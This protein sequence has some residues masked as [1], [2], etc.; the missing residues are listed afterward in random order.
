M[1]DRTSLVNQ[2]VL[3]RLGRIRES[4]PPPTDGRGNQL[5]KLLGALLK[6]IDRERRRQVRDALTAGPHGQVIHVLALSRL[7]AWLDLLHKQLL[8]YVADIGRRDIPLGIV[9]L[10]EGLVSDLLRGKADPIIHLNESYMYSTLAVQRSVKRV[11]D[12]WPLQVPI[13]RG[14]EPV[15]FNLPG[16]DHSNALLAPILAHE[17]GHVAVWQRQ[18]MAR[19]FEA[20]DRGGIEAAFQKYAAAINPANAADLK[21]VMEPVMKQFNFWL[22]ELLCDALAIELTGP[23]FLFACA[24]FLPAPHQGALGGHPFP[25]DRVEL[26][27]DHLDS[28]GWTDVLDELAPKTTVF[29]RG[30]GQP[31]SNDATE[32]FLREAVRIASPAIR[33]VAAAAV[34][35]HRLNPEAFR[36]ARPALAQ[37]LDV[38]VPPAAVEGAP[39]NTWTVLLASWLHELAVKG[40]N[41]AALVSISADQ[42]LSQF[43]LKA[44]E[45]SRIAHHWDAAVK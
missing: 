12:A 33:K 3:E 35:P 36:L 16:I 1:D 21:T 22:T 2:L 27:L 19:T 37:L 32:Q 43:I 41:P 5:I 6:A 28:I 29:L 8:P 30:L 44:I 4:I 24:V 15:I 9:Q 7:K 26:S 23:S 10:T 38:G 18:L 14:P 39:A 42:G 17:V 25:A 20:I 40:D 45:M 34:A 13:P 11:L 31:V